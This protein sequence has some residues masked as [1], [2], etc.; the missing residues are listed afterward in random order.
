MARPAHDFVG[1]AE[2]IH[3]VE[4][5]QCDIRRLEDVAAGVEYEIGP[6]AGL[7]VE[8]ISRRSVTFWPSRVNSFADNCMRA[9]TLLPLAT[10]RKFSTPVLRR[11]RGSAVCRAIFTRVIASRKRGLTPSGQAAMQSPVS[12]QPLAQALAA[13]GPSPKR[14]ISSTPEITAFGVASPMPAGPVTGQISTHLPHWVQ[15]SSI[16]AVRA[17]KAASKA[18][19]AMAS[20]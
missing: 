1:D 11:A 18:V 13:C 14:T 7:T 9:S 20:S 8:P 3:D 15:A 17:A 10:R 12:T 19:S 6:L 16:S 5:E 2:R 4:R